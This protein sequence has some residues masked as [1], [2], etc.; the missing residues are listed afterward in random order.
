MKNVSALK[1]QCPICLLMTFISNSKFVGYTFLD[2]LYLQEFEDIKTN[3][4]MNCN[5]N[6]R[7]QTVN[8]EK[9]AWFFYL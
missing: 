4:K 2:V 5:F 3:V 9:T 7:I 8:F 6:T 1:V